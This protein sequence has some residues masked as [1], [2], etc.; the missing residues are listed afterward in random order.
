MHKFM[1]HMSLS[2]KFIASL[3]HPQNSDCRHLFM[4]GRP[5]TSNG[6]VSKVNHSPAHEGTSGDEKLRAHSVTI[7]GNVGEAVVDF[8]KCE[9]LRVLDVEECKD[10]KDDHMDG[11]HKLWHMK[12]LSL[13]GTISQLPRK[14]EK[15][16]YL[17]TLDIRKAKIET[18]SVEVIKLPLLAHL[19][20][21]FKL[22]ERD[23]KMSE[24]GK[25]LPKES[26]LQTL[27]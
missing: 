20:G 12:Y 19:L 6:R 7:C 18:L 5:E 15:L 1:L 25:F 26:N 24:L 8:A 4:D 23:W 22:G 27:A 14:I 16:H 13:G 9:L 2:A 10:L 17:E 21:K 3:G 11:I